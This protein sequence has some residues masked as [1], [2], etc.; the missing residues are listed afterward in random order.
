MEKLMKSKIVWKIH[1]NNIKYFYVEFEKRIIL[2]R[3]NNF[4]DEPLLT[5]IDGFE[6]IDIEE[7]PSVWELESH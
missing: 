3:L 6:V 2:L 1:P 4:P 7:R 5:I